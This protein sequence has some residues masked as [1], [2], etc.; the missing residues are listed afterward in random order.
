MD[1]GVSLRQ[2]QAYA[3]GFE[4]DQKQRYL[5][6]GELLNQRIALLRLAGEL[7]PLQLAL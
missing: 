1:H 5:A 2:I 7:D 6:T 4:A 3:T